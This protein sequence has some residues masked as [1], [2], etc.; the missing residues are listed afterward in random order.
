MTAKK[1]IIDDFSYTGE[2]LQE[3]INLGLIPL[4]LLEPSN[5]KEL[6]DFLKENKETLCQHSPKE[7]KKDEP[8]QIQIPPSSEWDKAP[9]I[10]V[11]DKRTGQVVSTLEQVKIF[12]LCDGVKLQ[13]KAKEISQWEEETAGAKNLTKEQAKNLESFILKYATNRPLT[14][15]EIVAAIEEIKKTA[16]PKKYRQSGHLVDEKLKYNLPNK[17]QTLFDLISPETK[18]KIEE[19]KIEVK[20]EGIKLTPPENKLLH[21][22]NA[23]LHEKSFNN[24]NP[25]EEGFY[26][27]NSPYEVVGY[28]TSEAKSAVLKFKPSELYKE[29][30]GHEDYSGHDIQYIN[31]VLYKLESRKVLIKYDRVKKIKGGKTLT[32]RI[33]DFQPL[34]NIKSFIPDLSDDEKKKLDKGDP[35]IRERKGEIIIALN[36]IF[37]DQI[38]TK[39]I[40]FPMDTNRRLV[41]AAGGHRKVTSSMNTLMEWMLREKSAKRYKVQ[42]NEENLPYILGLDNY[43]KQNRK[44]KLKER[45]EKDIE[46]ITNMGIILSY[47]KTPNSEGAY[48][49]VFIINKDYE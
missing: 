33:E 27:G 13:V 16:K 34:I 6:V 40:E 25:K 49:W 31:G 5:W 23:I 14:R 32:D 18:Q 26:S 30:V 17:E 21:A 1:N 42:I 35:S 45:I 3:W 28:G 11:I 46:A 9:D 43:V 37:T 7:S 36:P 48:K 12:E 2:E 15:K 20:A 39:F 22:L 19:S 44:K 24:R 29:Y 38:D 8:Y 47:E 10:N 4:D 41:I